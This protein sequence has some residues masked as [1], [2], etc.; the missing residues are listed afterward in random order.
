MAGVVTKLFVS[1]LPEGC[2]P[3]E[4]RKRLENFG[5]TSGAYVA[6]KRDKGGCKFGFVSFRDVADREELVRNLRGVKMGE[7]RLRI[8][9]ARFAVENAGIP[10]EIKKQGGAPGVKGHIPVNVPSSFRDNRSYSHVVGSSDNVGRYVKGQMPSVG[11]ELQGSEKSVVIPDRSEAFK[12]LSGLALVGRTTDLETLVDFDRLL[13]IAKV[14]VSNIQYLGGLSLLISF[15]DEG[16]AT[17]FLEAK[18]IWGPWF[19]RLERW[20][21]QSLPFERVAWFNL[22]G[23]PLHL[24]SAEVFAQIGELYGK[25]LHVPSFVE[26]DQDLSLCR[27]G[28]LVGEVNRVSEC[29]SLR[30]KNRV[31]RLWVEEN[32]VEWVPDCIGPSAGQSSGEESSLRSS[33]IGNLNDSGEGDSGKSPE[34]KEDGGGEKPREVNSSSAHASF[35]PMHEDREN[36][37]SINAV[38]SGLMAEE[39]E[40]QLKSKEVGPGVV[41][42]FI[43]GSGGL[44]KRPKSWARQCSKPRKAQASSDV[45]KVDSPFDPRP[46][47][48]PEAPR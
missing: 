45:N 11:E 38:G 18:G 21:G 44:V 19:S 39:V 37:G 33:P 26:E 30:W 14:Q 10:D 40:G 47:K 22:S 48:D 4:L 1:N 12:S 36:G 29:V 9:I 46:L 5:V 8:N 32:P 28:V 27:I 35:F 34:L 25:V 2:T 3:W 43:C 31:Y 23:I 15:L 7:C 6:K 42:S 16:S 13:R 20:S 41:D 17:S 24:F